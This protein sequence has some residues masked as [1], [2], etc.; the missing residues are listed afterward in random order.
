MHLLLTNTAALLLCPPK[1]AKRLADEAWKATSHSK[2][3]VAMSNVLKIFSN[4]SD[5]NIVKEACCFDAV[6]LYAISTCPRATPDVNNWK[7]GKIRCEGKGRGP[8][9]CLGKNCELISWPVLP[10]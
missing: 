3:D 2:D 7:Y 4:V 1:K 6:I 5:E 9:L 8:D 10:H